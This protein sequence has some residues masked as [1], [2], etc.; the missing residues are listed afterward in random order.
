[1]CRSASLDSV[2]HDEVEI[3]YIVIFAQVEGGPKSLYWKSLTMQSL[4][5]MHVVRRMAP[6]APWA[7]SA[8]P[9]L[10]DTSIALKAEEA[11]AQCLVQMSCQ[12]HVSRE[13]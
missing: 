8:R 13:Q 12:V 7:A 11:A 9:V 4:F 6:R 1:M 5:L 2:L 3:I 10:K